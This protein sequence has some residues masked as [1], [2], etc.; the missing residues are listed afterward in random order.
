MGRSA[1]EGGFR[2]YPLAGGRRASRRTGGGNIAGDDLC[3]RAERGAGL[4]ADEGE[5][6][7]DAA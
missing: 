4:A 6:D 7:E 5:P 1:G 2:T 3:G